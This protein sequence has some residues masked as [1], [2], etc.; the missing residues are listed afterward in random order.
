MVEEF[1]W[2]GPDN[3]ISGVLQSGSGAFEGLELPLDSSLSESMSFS[4]VLFDSL[5][6]A[7]SSQL[8]LCLLL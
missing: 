4:S 6:V 5:A 2:S 7:M 1:I 3:A 8:C